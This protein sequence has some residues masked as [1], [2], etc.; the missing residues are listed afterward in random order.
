MA[1]ARIKARVDTDA[2]SVGRELNKASQQASAFA[3]RMRGIGKGLAAAFS[4][5]A[6]VQLGK[7]ILNASDRIAD[8]AANLGLTT[9]E[10]Q[11]FEGIAK[12]SGS[13]V[14][15][16]AVALER[17]SVVQGNIA[18]GQGEQAAE[19]LA[20]LG[21]SAEQ[22][23]GP[24]GELFAA[25]ARGFNETQNLGALDELFGRGFVRNVGTLRAI[26]QFP[27]LQ[28]LIAEQGQRGR[29]V[30][31]GEIMRAG[32]LSDTAEDLASR[33]LKFA[34]SAVTPGADDTAAAQLQREAVQAAT[35]RRKAIAAETKAKEE[36]ERMATLQSAIGKA[37][38]MEGLGSDL[39][40]IGARGGIRGVEDEQ[41]KLAKEQLAK[42]KEIAGNTE[43]IDDLAPGG[44]FTE[45]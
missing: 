39:V 12:I 27:S 20:A 10:L 1:E 35:E 32:G 34:T 38:P 24:L 4:A 11:A 37:S 45:P 19:S 22:A 15:G 33:A 23:Q 26:G 31:A 41:V 43:G 6:V 44:V 3:S 7:N 14:E 17:L 42:L 16:L 2:S 30:P 5:G 25:I 40:R 29:I 21:V 8:A 13:S 9:D 18:A 36:A 28:E